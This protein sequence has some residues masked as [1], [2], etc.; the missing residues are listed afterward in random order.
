MGR[1]QAAILVVDDV[2]DNLTAIEA[3]LDGLGHRPVFA[4]S[5]QEALRCLL[6]RDFALILLDV[7]MPSMNGLETARLIRRRK[8]SR[9]VPIIF[10]T[11][12]D[13]NDDEI[14]A[15]YRLGAVDF[16]FKPI[17]PEILRAK[18]S[19]F[20]ELQRRTAEVARQA[21]TNL[22]LERMRAQLQH[23]NQRLALA[24]RRK[25]EFIAMLA[26]ELRNPL[27]AIMSGLE[28]L[29]VDPSPTVVETIRPAMT[30]QGLHLMRLVDDL[31]DI[32]RITSGK[33][34][35]HE[36]LIR[37]QQVLDDAVELV[38][39][40]VIAKRQL[41]DIDCDCGELRICGDPVR[42]AQVVANLLSNAAR[43]TDPGG[44]IWLSARLDQRGELRI[45]V[46]DD[47]R[48]MPPSLLSRVFELFVQGEVG[49]GGLGIGL[50]LVRQLTQMHGGEVTARSEGLGRGSE[51]ELRLPLAGDQR[52]RRLAPGERSSELGLAHKRVALIDDDHDVRELTRSVLE[53]WGHSVVEAAHGTD[54]IAL[55]LNERPDIAIIDIGLDDIEGYEVARRLRA[56]LGDR[57]PRLI[58]MT[59][60]GRAQDRERAFAAGFHAYLPK[61]AR[62][63]ALRSA[64][65]GSVD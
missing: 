21:Q 64:M 37:V 4:R 56:E 31:L 7:Q 26:H 60:F 42:L 38:S 12:H 2:P 23:S 27:A 65:H 28:V 47:G 29:A 10:I 54:G 25:D 16:L 48:G 41:L 39:P 17:H 1:D 49:G 43:Y 22:A 8:R 33:L 44:H 46:R 6:E 45:C 52:P 58:A 3:A 18:V 61:P 9:H 63:E 34:Q 51:F 62:S 32:A 14:L 59:G 40:D 5:G 13:R 55:V 15:G 30:R 20:V 53:H 11:A 24:D 50:T 36:Q 19:V 57:C 35:L